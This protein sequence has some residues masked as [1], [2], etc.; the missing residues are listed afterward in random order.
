ME[1]IDKKDRIL[2]YELRKNC[3]QTYSWLAKATSLS[4]QMVQYRINRL[5]RLGVLDGTV[6]EI[7]AA[8]LGYQ[9]YGVYFQWEDYSLKEAF[10]RDL[11]KHPFLRY[12]AEGSGRM[13]FVV[14]F[15]AKTP[16]EFQH[17]WDKLISKHGSTIRS[18]SIHASTENRAFER[19]HLIGEHRRKGKETFLGSAGEKTEIDDHDIKIL[20]IL[21][22]NA[23]ASLIS[24]AKKCNLTAETVKSR[25]KR[26]EDEGLIQGY[27]WVYNREPLGLHQYELLLSLTNMDSEKWN[28]LLSYCRSNTHISYF[29]RS[30]GEFDAT[31]IFEV[32]SEAEFDKEFRELRV[33]FSRNIHDFEIVKIVK[34][35]QFKYAPFL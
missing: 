16:V 22:L 1:N 21:A 5:V 34:E 8:R 20:K 35:H 13:D 10:V 15:Y 32:Y 3:R 30:I 11:L 33:R 25:I 23:R 7:D 12:A 6:L 24:I 17:I 26:M 27:G 29:I 14:S 18:H 28:A 4:K 19:S 2:L 9:N 31:I